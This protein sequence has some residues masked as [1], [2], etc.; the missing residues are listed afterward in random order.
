MERGKYFS[1]KYMSYLLIILLLIFTIGSFYLL[2]YKITGL[3]VYNQFNQSEF[4]LGIYSN[5]EWNGSAVVLA[6][7]NLSGTYTSKIFDADAEAI[8]NNLTWIGSE[9][10]LE[11]FFCVDG[12]GE[13]YKSVDAGVNWVMTKENYGRTTSTSSMFSDNNYL[14]ILSGS[15]KEV[16]RSSDSGVSFNVVND[17]FSTDSLFVG[18]SDSN[19]NLYV[20]TG[21]GDVFKSIDSGLTWSLLSDFNLG[22]QDPKG[23][24]INS[25]NDIYI[26]DGAGDVYSSVDGGSNWTKVNDGY[27]GSTGTDGIVVDSSDNLYI[28]VGSDVYSSTDSGVTWAKIND[29][30]S[31]YS[32]EGMEIS[33]DNNDYLWIADGA[34]RVFKSTNSGIDWSEIGD[35]NN[36]AGSDPKGLTNFVQSSDLDIQVKSCNDDSCSGESW[37]DISDNSPQ[38]LSLD[39]NQY[40]QYKVDFTSPDS[41]ISPNLQSINIDYD[42][43]DSEFPQISFSPSTTTSGEYNQDNIFVG[44]NVSD[45]SQTYSFINF[46]NSLNAFYKLNDTGATIKDYSGNNYDGTNTGAISTDGKFGNALEFNTGD[47][48][49]FGN[50]NSFERT[51]SFS[52][53][54]WINTDST[55]SYITIMSKTPYGSW[56]GMELFVV[57]SKIKFYLIGAAEQI[58]ISG[59]AT[60]NT[61]NWKHIVIT[62]DGNS[63][64][65]GVKI[66]VDNVEGSS[67]SGT[68]TTSIK[69]SNNFQVSGRAGANNCFNGLLDD[70]LIFNRVL[71]LGEIS[72]LYNASSYSN[73]FTNLVDGSYDF[74]AYSQDTNGYENQTKTRTANLVSNLAPTITLIHPQNT[75]YTE[76]ELLNLNYSVSDSDGNLDSCWY[77]IDDGANV[78][79]I[80]CAN[81]TFNVLEDGIYTINLF[82]NDSEGL[83]SSDSVSFNVDVT[84][85]SLS[86]SE[87]TGTKTSRTSIPLIYNVI[88]TDVLCWYNVKTSVGGDV[89]ANT[90]LINCTGSSFDV[91]TD[92]DYVL[93]LYANNTLGTFDFEASSFSVDTSGGTVIINSGGGGGGSGSTIITGLIELEIGTLSDLIVYLGDD[94]RLSLNVK[95]VGTSILNDCSITEKGDSDFWVLS[96][97]TKNLASGEIY[98]F[99]FNLAISDIVEIGKYDLK[100]F[101]QC[102][103]INKSVD[104]IV[105]IMERNLGFEILG[106]ERLTDEQVKVTYLLEELS[107]INQEVEMQFLLFD[108]ENKKVAEIKEVKNVL[109][110]SKEEFE[111][112]IPIDSSLLGEMNLLVNLNSETYSTFIQKDIILGAPISGLAVFG[113]S[114]NVDKAISIFLILVFLVAAFFIIKRILRHRKK[115]VKKKRKK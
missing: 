62:Y 84:G 8:W 71:S 110:N 55:T 24:A 86:I 29:D 46:D 81:T 72:A 102:Q 64:A 52:Y 39:N 96:S 21:P 31:P 82:A 100:V 87:P 26:V 37:E 6:G 7:E 41:S 107:N 114:G 103:E 11:S 57:N 43:L 89:I 32:N 58:D 92:G 13:I 101:L 73:N 40:F 33:I 35:C 47:Y 106:V 115:F 60:V 74:Y 88:G 17:T 70:I 36:A 113:D 54:F 111:I 27:G 53:S 30:F 2:D 10:D 85:I 63:S 66:Y 98:D 65:S 5:T 93:N 9:P 90:T 38:D 83:E 94:K 95:N 15:N 68:L 22:T 105:E 69:N 56:Q 23:I 48:I 108:V 112:I 12:G 91:S 59:T 20:T 61:G 97:E 1:K 34:G 51:D 19:N 44:I 78:S 67:G 45:D 49:N 76:N 79:L 4:D 80:S 50:I 75:L 28:L 109:A 104:L 77:N 99:V 25:S 14:Y 18:T 42:L 3:A 16:W